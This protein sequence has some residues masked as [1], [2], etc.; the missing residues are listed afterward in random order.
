[1]ETQRNSI[2]IKVQWRVYLDVAANLLTFASSVC[3]GRLPSLWTCTYT[4][5]PLSRSALHTSTHLKHRNTHTLVQQCISLM[6]IAWLYTKIW[7]K[8]WSTCFAELFKALYYIL[9]VRLFWSAKDDTV[10]VHHKHTHTPKYDD[11]PSNKLQRLSLA[12][13]AGRT[14]TTLREK[15]RTEPCK[16]IV[17]TVASLPRDYMPARV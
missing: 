15:E 14:C 7:R 12:L 17:I 11:L 16:S 5:N 10:P 4:A 13:M 2:T 6:P 1:M 8:K 3:T 9:W